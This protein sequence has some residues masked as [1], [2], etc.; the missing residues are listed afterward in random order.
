MSEFWMVQAG[1]GGYMFDQFADKNCVAIGWA[2]LGDLTHVQK[3]EDLARLLA[4][5]YPDDKKQAAGINVATIA[6]FRFVIKP[7]DRVTTY[8][9]TTREYL[10]GRVEGDY[11]YRPDFEARMPNVRRVCWLG[12][13]SRD[14]LSQSS[15]NKLGAHVAIFQPG[16]EVEQEFDQLLAG[17]PSTGLDEPKANDGEGEIERIRREIVDKSHEF[18]KDR[19]SSLD[20]EEMQELV[21]AV[22]RAM[23]YKTRVSPRGSDQGKDIVASPDGLGLAPPRIKVEIK[24]RPKQQMGSADLRSFL[25][26]LRQNDRGLYVSTG[27]FSKEAVYE[28][29]R[30]TIPLGLLT[31]DDLASLV[32]QHYENLD[33]DGRALIPLTRFYWP[34]S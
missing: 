7:D 33:S 27:G 17:K 10:V 26:G 31:L 6:K 23:G 15:R 4:K 32:A 25:G 28:A 18:I 11:E 21:A 16:T 14:N 13:I 20:W 30:A 1:S 2:D 34:A 19:I 5:A 8:N 29:E 24:H 3:R 22:L 9:P 12:R